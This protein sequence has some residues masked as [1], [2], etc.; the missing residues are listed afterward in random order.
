M[1]FF[2]VR[3]LSSRLHDLD[4]DISSHVAGN[5]REDSTHSVVSL[6][7][8]HSLAAHEDVLR[9]SLDPS[10]LTSGGSHGGDGGLRDSVF[11]EDDHSDVL[12]GVNPTHHQ[13]YHDSVEVEGG[14]K[15]SRKDNRGR[16]GKDATARSTSG[17]FK[18]SVQ[19]LAHRTFSRAGWNWAGKKAAP[20]SP[21]SV[22]SPCAVKDGFFNNNNNTITSIKSAEDEED[23]YRDMTSP[24]LS[25]STPDVIDMTRPVASHAEENRH[26][27]SRDDLDIQVKSDTLHT[28][29]CGHS[30]DVKD[31]SKSPHQAI[32]VNKGHRTPKDRIISTMVSSS[33]L[34]GVSRFDGRLQN[35]S[36]SSPDLAR[37][38]S[39]QH[40]HLISASD[41]AQGWG[42]P[43]LKGTGHVTQSWRPSNLTLSTFSRPCGQSSN[44][45]TSSHAVSETKV[46]TP[47]REV[48]PDALAQIEVGS[49]IH[50]LRSHGCL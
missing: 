31:D 38:D 17:G 25:E 12:G 3:S 27:T 37:N 22:S 50:Y 44:T 41:T 49:F 9:H 39:Q 43:R 32:I 16:E 14:G 13:R 40:S 5:S 26:Q 8:K 10:C 11:M 30:N 35:F 21:A 42:Q 20:T 34:S 23:F 7:N 33:S 4:E 24:R 19:K 6:R 48:N 18:S 47:R 1:F 45:I 2:Q 36:S 29:Q 15:S 28:Y 46:V